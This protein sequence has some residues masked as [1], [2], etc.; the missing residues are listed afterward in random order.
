M[1]EHEII[2]QI[3]GG[4]IEKYRLLL[5]RYQK[6]LVHHCLNMVND[7]DIANDLTQEACIKAYLQLKRYKEDYR[8]STWLY[9]IATNL[10]LDF[11]K[12]RRHVSL[13]D[14]PE[15]MS[16]L[17]SPQEQIIKNEVT[18]KLYQTIKQLP[19]KYQTVISL[20]YWQEQSYEEIA[21]I[22]NVPLGTVRTW[23][24]RAKDALKEELNG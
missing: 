22:M 14:I 8:F 15:P 3:L 10:C 7:Y 12:K 18:T 4:D 21:E 2:K 23:L 20:Y 9:K 24:K 19:L 1:D 11:L 13:D 6:G 17:P 5:E 16:N